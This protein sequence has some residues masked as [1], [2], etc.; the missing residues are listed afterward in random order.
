MNPLRRIVEGNCPVCDER[1]ADT[2][3]YMGRAEWLLVC[4]DC[5]LKSQSEVGIELEQPFPPW[6][7]KEIEKRYS[8]WRDIGSEESEF[9]DD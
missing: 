3:K 1:T 6:K 5:W 2:R 9:D 8:G 7:R 4:G